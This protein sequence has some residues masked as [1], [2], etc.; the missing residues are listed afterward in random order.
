MIAI[1][2]GLIACAGAAP[3]WRNRYH[4]HLSPFDGSLDRYLNEQMFDTNMF[5]EE[6]NREM[7]QLET[8]LAEFTSRFP[9]LS[10]SEKF[11]GNEYKI[12][13]PLTGFKEKDIVVKARKGMI[14]I[15]AVHVNEGNNQNSYLDMRTLPQNVGEQGTWSYEND[16]LK[17]VLPVNQNAGSNPVTASPIPDRSI[18]ET[19]NSK[20]VEPNVDIDLVK[21][22]AGKAKE[23]QTNEIPNVEATTYAVDLKGEV[24]FVP[25]RY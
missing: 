21:A 25:V 6:M 12:T 14:M 3:S 4:S 9:T 19:E 13:I 7:A 16:V 15:Q 11:E 22:D 1:L 2:L 24:E 18:E 10:S 23:I 8:V 17:I 20:D 5:F